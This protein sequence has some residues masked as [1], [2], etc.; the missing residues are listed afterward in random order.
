[1]V[2]KTQ[3]A[4]FLILI[5]LVTQILGKRKKIDYSFIHKCILEL[6]SY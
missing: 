2:S 5:L 6:I 1:V 3:F 4:P